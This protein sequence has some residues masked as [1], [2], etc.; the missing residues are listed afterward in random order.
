MKKILGVFG[1]IFVFSFLVILPLLI[2]IKVDCKSQYGDCPRMIS[3]KLALVD[4]KSLFSARKT[5]K[6]LLKNEFVV[7]DYSLQYK[8]PNILSVDLLVKKPA[9]T[10][11]SLKSGTLALVDAEGKVLSIA[12]GSALPVISITG[13]LPKAGQDVG[14]DELFALNLAG[15]VYQMYQVREFLLQDSSLLVELPGRFRVIFPLD[16]DIRILLGALR[17]IY[18]KIQ[19]E[20]NPAGY[21]QVDLRFTNPVLR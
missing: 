21:S 8:I 11:K 5:V 18:S 4:G 1:I 14:K 13:E 15:G 2:K 3:D 7:S 17:L 16:G 20:G 12:S 9:I 19:S 10:F 6:T